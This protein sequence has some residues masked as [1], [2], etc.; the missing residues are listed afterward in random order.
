MFTGVFGFIEGCLVHMKKNIQEQVS[1]IAV[2]HKTL[3]GFIFLVC[4]NDG[5]I[6]RKP[7]RKVIIPF[8]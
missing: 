1:F 4:R 2:K 5:R 8:V 7:G 3:Y 6:I